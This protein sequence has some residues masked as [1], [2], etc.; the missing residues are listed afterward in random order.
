MGEANRRRE[1]ATKNPQPPKSGGGSGGG[2][3]DPGFMMLA[4]GYPVPE[5][6]RSHIPP[7]GGCTVALA[8][9][10]FF[11]VSAFPDLREKEAAAL[12]SKPMEIGMLPFGDALIFTLGVDGYGD[13]DMPYDHTL[14]PPDRRWPGDRL[15]E[16]GASVTVLGVDSRTKILRALRYVTVTPEFCSVLDAEVAKINARVTA[17][18]WDF[19]GAV[20][21][22]Y[23]IWP[24]SQHIARSA[25]YRE[26]AGMKFRKERDE[27]M[28][29]GAH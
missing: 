11:I 28:P 29:K 5:V 20:G 23:Q 13:F 9:D 1:W 26:T 17:P 16:N 12:Q 25:T 4:V 6:F 24:T 3:D 27:P 15:P 19:F 18:D 14:V 21:R 2:G 8:N 22:A 7:H 10:E